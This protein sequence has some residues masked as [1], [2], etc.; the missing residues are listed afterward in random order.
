M[1]ECKQN[2]QCGIYAVV[3]LVVS[4][5]NRLF[6][7]EIEVEDLCSIHANKVIAEIVDVD[8][9]F[10]LHLEKITSDSVVAD[11][12]FDRQV[13]YNR[14]FPEAVSFVDVM[15]VTFEKHIIEQETIVTDTEFMIF[16][17][18]MAP[19]GACLGSVVLNTEV[20]NAAY[21][22]ELVEFV[23]MTDNCSVVLNP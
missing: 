21:R 1:A 15:T 6:E 17:K 2:K 13:E 11:S 16:N 5:D 9:V 22:G 14:E 7:D 23:E 20:L 12:V 19:L 8:S 3:C 10:D 4:P 18:K